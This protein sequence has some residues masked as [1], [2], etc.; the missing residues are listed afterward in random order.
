M[1]RQNWL[2]LLARNI[3]ARSEPVPPEVTG[4]I[5]SGG[6]ARAS[7]H[8]GASRYLYDVVG[9]APTSIVG[10][11]AGSI[12][13]AMLAQSLDPTVQSKELRELERLWLGMTS[14]ADM[15]AEQT[16]FTNLRG[17]LDGLGGLLGT[18]ADDAEPVLAGDADEPNEVVKR[19]LDADPSR[20][21]VLSPTDVWQLAGSLLRV[22]RVGAGLAASV[23]GAEKAA[24]AYRP[25]P[26]VHRLLFESTFRSSRIN[27]SGVKLRLAVVDLDSGALRFMRQDGIIVD[28]DDNPIDDNAYDVA[29]GVW[30]SCSIPGVFRPV[31]LG[32][33]VYVDGGVRENLPIE[34]AV[35]NLGVTKP[36]VVVAQPP[37]LAP[38][39]FAAKDI[40]SVLLRVAS[41][42]LDE[43]IQDEVEWARTAGA[44]VIEPHIDVHDA[45]TVEPALLRINRDYGWTRAAEEVTGAPASLREVNE[46]IC[47]ARC[48]WAELV[49]PKPSLGVTV[50]PEPTPPEPEQVAALQSQLRTLLARAD[51]TL[52]PPGHETWA[53]EL[54][55]ASN[56]TQ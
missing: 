32:N 1:A 11:S 29:L 50:K 38:D 45:G 47:Q 9:I 3:S 33:G 5:L 53:D 54:A 23:R 37:G 24:S 16:W 12:V 43:T 49:H 26:I 39:D 14:T 20:D 42:T 40:I 15:F 48:D 7:F 44:C 41:I 13:A 36:Y 35:K 4:L 8:I 30:A 51:E 10:T 2:D 46:A 52:L 55:L 17:H 18:H 28:R 19:A 25:G 56:L 31:K 34:M 21:M 22:G 27:K 6:G